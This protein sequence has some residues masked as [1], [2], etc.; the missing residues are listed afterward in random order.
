VNVIFLAGKVG[1]DAELRSTPSGK[2]VLNWK[3]VVDVGWG[4]RKHS[5]WIECALFGV[6]AEKLAPHITKGKPITVYGAFDLRTYQAKNGPGASITCDVQDLQLQGSLQS[7]RPAAEP[8][9]D[10]KAADVAFD[11][12]LAF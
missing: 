10:K 12:D 7:D 8:F 6:R 3:I 4:E 11:D 9:D 1:T 5:L 2:P